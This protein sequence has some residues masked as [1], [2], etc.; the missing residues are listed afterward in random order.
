ML[1]YSILS[2]ILS[3]ASLVGL[4]VAGYERFCGV[5]IKSAPVAVG[6]SVILNVAVGERV[7]IVSEGSIEA[8]L[9]VRKLLNEELD[10]EAGD[11][12]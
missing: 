10:T 3:M 2:N 11:R 8:L 7:S 5:S 12:S 1:L 9:N 6:L 4:V